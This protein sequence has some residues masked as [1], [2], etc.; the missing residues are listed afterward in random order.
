MEWDERERPRAGGRRHHVPLHVHVR[1]E[2]L[3]VP[4]RDGAASVDWLGREALR[5]YAKNKPGYGCLSEEAAFIVR[6][7]QGLALLDPHD[8][9]AEVLENNDFVEVV[10]EDDA[11]SPDF[12]QWMPEHR[13]SIYREPDEVNAP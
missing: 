5:R 6:R 2:W 7:C 3:L 10:L 1:D 9:L 11:V 12:S 8:A 4:S 13:S